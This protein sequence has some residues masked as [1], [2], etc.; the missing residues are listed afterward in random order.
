M[1]N[2]VTVLTYGT[3]DLFHIG[4]LR[5]LE[6]AK[7]LGD[8]LIVGVS[9]DEF[10]RQK[11]KQTVIPYQQRAEIVDHICFV[12]HVIPEQSWEQKQQDILRYGVDIFVMGDD[13]QGHFD[14]LKPYCDVFYLPRT[15]DISTTQLK[16][17]LKHEHYLTLGEPQ[18]AIA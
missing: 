15:R 4:H 18:L 14:F 13:W 11:N 1:T 8:E 6:R 5:I 2:K 10:N 17:N 16:Q 3:F 9:S 7:Q 12:D